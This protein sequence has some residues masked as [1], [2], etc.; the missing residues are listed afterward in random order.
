M[1]AHK[2]KPLDPR[3]KAAIDEVQGMILVQYPETTFDVGEPDEHGV[4]FMRAI[5]DVDDPDEVTE[6]V[7]DRQVD[8]LVDEGLPLYVIA[9]RTPAREAAERQR[10]EKARRLYA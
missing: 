4:V 1:T 7:I 6:I 3:M 5:A 8:L 10:Q 2:P 9:L